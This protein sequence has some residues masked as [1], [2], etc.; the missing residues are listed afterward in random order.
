LA[1]LAVAL[2][3]ATAIQ[4]LNWNATSHYALIQAFHDGTPSIDDYLDNAPTGDR[5]GVDGHWYSSRAPGLAYLSQPAYAGLH[6]VGLAGGDP[7]PVGPHPNDRAVWLLGL[8]AAVLPGFVL[9]LLVRSVAERLEPG[10]GTVAA[11]TVGL[12]TLLLPF[13]TLLFAHVLAAALTFGSFT[14]L[15]G[16]RNRPGGPRTWALGAAGL[17]AGLAF[18]TEYPAALAGVVLAGYAVAGAAG[19]RAA[20]G[21]FWPYA[22]GAFVGSLPLALYNKWAFGSFTKLAYSGLEEHQQ[23][24]FG[25]DTPDPGVAAQ[26]L[27]TSRGLLTLA[28]VL[29]MAAIGLVL[30][31]RR[32]WRAEALACG[33]IA[34]VLLVYN[35]G[36]YLPF[37]GETPG[38]RFLILSLPFLGVGLASAFARF[39]GPTVA[40][41]GASI[42]TMTIATIA[43][44]AVGS[45]P[46]TGIWTARLGNGELQ[47]SAFTE[48]GVDRAWLAWTPA[49]ALLVLA[50]VVAL[51]GVPRPSK[52]QLGA[53]LAAVAAWALFAALG[54]HALGIDAAAEKAVALGL[55]DLPHPYGPQPIDTLALI[56]AVAG[57]LALVAA[58]VSGRAASAAPA[59][60]ATAG[61]RPAG[62][63]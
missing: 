38:P 53:G 46:E 25:I 58:R 30:V 5:V 37:G 39:P 57:A 26:L 36:Y 28:P 2:F 63:P 56:G 15:F 61:S 10:L 51:R 20:L 35:S 50:L 13:S 34:L 48:L 43:G 54:P 62:S 27:L 55:G 19:L 21:R 33:A 40:L 52:R 23:G 8:W 47:A 18:I 59:R 44:P 12:G 31:W 32:G 49:L 6:L 1:V 17:L 14:V 16:E 42:A 7:V 4:P 9:L 11:V 3:S 60:A 29:V 45:E 24:F 22:V 41:A